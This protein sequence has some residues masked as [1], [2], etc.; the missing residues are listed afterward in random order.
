[1]IGPRLRLLRLFGIPL[2]VDLSWFLIVVLIKEVARAEWPAT[3]VAD[4]LEPCGPANTIERGRDAMEA[5]S[6]MRERDRS[7]LMVVSGDALVGVVSLKDLMGFL[8][9]KVELAEKGE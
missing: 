5:L 6:R 8:A 3:R 4:V 7:R 2:Y 1:M 9:L